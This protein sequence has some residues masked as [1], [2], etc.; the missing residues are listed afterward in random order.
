MK[1]I[2]F[3][4]NE[5]VQSLMSKYTH[6]GIGSFWIYEVYEIEFDPTRLPNEIKE[7]M[8]QLEPDVART[9][10]FAHIDFSKRKTMNVK[11]ENSMFEYVKHSFNIDP[12]KEL[13]SRDKFQYHLTEQDEQNTVKFITSLLLNYIDVHIK[14]LT[15]A[16]KSRYQSKLNNL[17]KDISS[18]K[19]SHECLVIMHNHFNYA[20]LNVDENKHGTSVPGAQWNLSI[21][22]DKTRIKHITPEML[23]LGPTI[24]NISPDI[25]QLGWVIGEEVVVTE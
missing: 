24:D 10:W 5:Y 1:Y 16:D 20:M 8:I 12:T 3:E 21:P 11:V 4:R 9:V 23:D 7:C 18:C 14:S 22:G 6:K 13:H 19:T 25:F 15:P 2:A 17:K